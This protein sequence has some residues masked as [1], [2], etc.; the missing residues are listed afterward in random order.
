MSNTISVNNPNL[1]P[2]VRN[3]ALNDGKK[4]QFPDKVV[5]EQ[6]SEENRN[7]GIK[8]EKVQAG[9]IEKEKDNIHI[10]TVIE[11]KLQESLEQFKKAGLISQEDMRTLLSIMIPNS[12]VEKDS[13]SPTQNIKI[14]ELA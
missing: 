7:I 9:N 14:N 11:K 5:V 1:Y 6:E 8:D 2:P 10:E 13:D 3:V 12:I 4:A